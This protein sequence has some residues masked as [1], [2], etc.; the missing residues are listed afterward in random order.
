MQ[1]QRDWLPNAQ[2]YPPPQTWTISPEEEKVLAA[3]DATMDWLSSLPGSF[4]LPYAGK[5]VAAKD[6]NIVASGDTHGELLANLGDT[7][8][9][10]VI[11]HRV[12]PL[13]P[14]IY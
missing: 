7:D 4:F 10:T 11:I 3:T 8:L 9:S 13:G 1:R 14:V 6:C 5:W 2:A 12:P